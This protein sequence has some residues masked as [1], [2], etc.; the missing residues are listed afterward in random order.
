[1]SN[2]IKSILDAVTIVWAIT[3]Y[4][5]AGQSAPRMEDV[6]QAWQL[7]LNRIKQSLPTTTGNNGLKSTTVWYQ[8]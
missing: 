7:S 4:L 2:N 6:F 1:M 5:S 3:L 8:E